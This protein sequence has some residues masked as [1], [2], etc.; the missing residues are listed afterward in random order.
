MMIRIL[1]T[2]IKKAIIILILINF[3]SLVKAETIIPQNIIKFFD[4]CKINS[5]LGQMCKM[6]S[7]NSYDYFKGLDEVITDNVAHYKE[8]DFWEFFFTI[9]E[10]D[11]NEAIIG[12]E[13]LA[14]RSSYKSYKLLKFKYDKS[15]NTWEI[16][17]LKSIFPEEDS[18]YQ[19]I[20][21]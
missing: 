5:S 15:K 19:L 2:V 11:E 14:L 17:A 8:G 6:D 4:I 16:H 21:K 1:F 18:N 7:F 9:K 13:D 10:Q 20:S 3:T 12:F